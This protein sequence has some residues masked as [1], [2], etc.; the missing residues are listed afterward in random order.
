M[1]LILSIAG[2]RIQIDASPVVLSALAKR[3]SPFVGEAREA[4][5][6]I[7]LHITA[8]RRH[9]SPELEIG[10]PASLRLARGGGV[11]LTGAVD[12]LFSLATRSGWAREVQG[13]GAVDALLR[14]ALS[15]SLPL[16][17]ALLLH[18]A[19]VIGNRRALTLVGGSGSGK[20]TAARAFGGVCDELLVVRPEAGEIYAFSTP[21]WNGR[22]AEAPLR[23]LVCLERGTA[24]GVEKLTGAAAVRSVFPHV[25]R[26]L[27]I[28]EIDRAS[29]G[30]V[31]ELCKRIDIYRATCP[32]GER[33]VPLLSHHFAAELAA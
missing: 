29:L 4:R 18:G 33:L 11:L 1:R 24:P 7:S 19:L 12:G 9:F 32:D 13:L 3:Y 6:S 16:D 25:V 20:S 14:A 27:A 26:Y 31:A 2:E 10:A 5:G 8:S 22:P 21:Y 30:L 15:L 17:G 28:E 23:A